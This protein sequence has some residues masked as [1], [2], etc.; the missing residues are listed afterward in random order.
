MLVS[1][2]TKIN[3]YL[4]A[5]QNLAVL[6]VCLSLLTTFTS[7]ITI[8][9]YPAEIYQRG[10]STGVFILAGSF[11]F[12]IVGRY[13]IP[14]ASIYSYLE[15]R[16]GS[17]FLRQVGTCA[18]LINTFMYMSLVIYAPAVAIS[19]LVNLPLWPFIT[20]VGLVGTSTALGGIKGVVW[21]DTLQAGGL[22]KVIFDAEQT[23]RLTDAIFKFD[24]NPFQ[25]SNLWA[26][27]IGGTLQGLST[28]G[29]HQMSLQR[30]LSMSS[31]KK[32][33]TVLF[34]TMPAYLFVS[35]ITLYLGLL[36]FGY[37]HGCDPLALKEI[38]TRDQLPILLAF[39]VMGSIPEM[40]GLFLSAI[41]SATLSTISSGLNS[42][43]TVLWEEFLKK[44][45]QSDKEKCVKPDKLMKVL[46]ITFGLLTTLTAFAY[47]FFG[48]IFSIFF[49]TLGATN[50][51][52][53]GLFILGL[54]FPRAN[55]NGAVIGFFS[56]SI[57]MIF[58]SVCSALN[59]PY[60][61]YL[62]PM[63]AS[64][65]T[66]SPACSANNSTNV[67]AEFYQT[68]SPNYHYGSGSFVLS[69]ISNF[70]FITIGILTTVIVA[71]NN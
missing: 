71:L 20:I 33:K 61:D 38:K 7:G 18:F 15:C 59:Q 22:Q 42:I 35:L 44:K 57:L 47:K 3:A 27:L 17:I 52:I 45:Y 1:V 62:L 21:A 6:P 29:L 49:T 53:A 56:S 23:G 63:I 46:I 43:A 5:D 54:M 67:V 24:P 4:N 36:L 28:F 48:S 19:G 50:G 34:L 31:L 26:A 41:F 69:R 30:Y 65:S 8:L 37:F 58:I 39:K 13:F 70:N 55:R 16:F 10:A 66:I 40:S 51:P 60:K 11:G 32:A 12:F 68:K 9:A 25:Y 14:F 2:N 64:N